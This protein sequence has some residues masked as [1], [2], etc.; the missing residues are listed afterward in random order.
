MTEIVSPGRGE[1]ETVD[2]NVGRAERRWP[3]ALAVLV[4]LGLHLALPHDFRVPPLW[5]YPALVVILLALLILGDPGLIDSE[6]TWLR[7]ATSLLVV[8][9]VVSNLWSAVILVH[10]IFTHAQFYEDAYQ[11]LGIGAIIWT[12]NVIAFALW[13][14]DVDGGGPARRVAQGSWADPAFVFPEMEIDN[15]VTA[16][17]FPRFI[18]YLVLSFNTATSFGPTD[19]A[20]IKR[21]AKVIM[22]TES[23]SA[24]V[25]VILVLGKAI[26]NM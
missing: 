16:G 8:V 14:W 26:N 1:P 9:I 7:R 15:L 6:K 17:W 2:A 3:M 23:A 11:L 20:V 12:I 18:D 19:V 5:L 24:L 25:L 4:A 21:W 10:G 22:L 13:F